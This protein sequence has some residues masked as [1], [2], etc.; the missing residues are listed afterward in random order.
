MTF[1]HMNAARTVAAALVVTVITQVLYVTGIVGGGSE[2]ASVRMV[3]TT[4]MA[5]FTILAVIGIAMAARDE[6]SPL[7]WAA[8]AVA[9]FVNV[10]QTGMGL[11]MFPPASAAG[12]G[13]EPLMGTVVA[14]A[15]F[16]YFHGK[17]LIGLAAIGFGLRAW[18]SGTFA[19]KA[20][21]GLGVLAGMAAAVL[22][23]LGMAG[24]M[25]WA[26]PAG[27]SG[28]AAAAVLAL[29]LVLIVRAP[30]PKKVTA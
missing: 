6:R 7:A 21:G 22:N 25:R 11:A 26:Q 27:A 18:A 17:A 15:F 9:G 8:I 14:G 16:L 30:S 23:L 29:L 1:N 12:E 10:L 19:A 20:I 5:M 28:T 13:L 3:W 2:A 24:G 4:E